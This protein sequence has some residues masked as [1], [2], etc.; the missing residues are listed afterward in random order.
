M[1][2]KNER[3]QGPRLRNG[4]S[5]YTQSLVVGWFQLDVNQFT[6]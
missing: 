3:Q 4:C 2:H 1:T 6:K 5:H